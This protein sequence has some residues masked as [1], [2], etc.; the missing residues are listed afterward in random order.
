MS[1]KP[2]RHT[3]SVAAP[4]AAVRDLVLANRMLAHEGVLD[5]FGH[6]SARHPVNPARYLISRAVAPAL[7]QGEDILALDLDGN[8]IGATAATLY[9][10]RFL[11][12]EI[13]RRRPDV[14][15]IVH[16]HS[17]ATIPFGVTRMKLRPICH[18][19]GFLERMR[20]YSTSATT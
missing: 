17:P 6:V 10:E 19:S 5:A 14:Q 9:L 16:S 13:Y 7:V 20:R 15:A 12:G 4:Y 1:T 2:K 18:M 8:P 3:G 11:H